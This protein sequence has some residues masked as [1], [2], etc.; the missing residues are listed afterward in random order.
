MVVVNN[1]RMVSPPNPVPSAAYKSKGKG[2]STCFLSSFFVL[3]HRKLVKLVTPL[4]RARASL[5]TGSRLFGMVPSD[6]P[7]GSP[8]NAISPSKSSP[9]AFYPMKASAAAAGTGGLPPLWRPADG[10]GWS[11]RVR[12]VMP[13]RCSSTGGPHPPDRKDPQC[14]KPCIPAQFLSIF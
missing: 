5:K 14:L 10:V 4:L 13:T 12:N 9:G 6:S 3:F 8:P 7:V 2:K 1:I 11:D